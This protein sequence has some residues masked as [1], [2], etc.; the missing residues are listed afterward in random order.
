MEKNVSALD[1]VSRSL[2]FRWAFWFIFANAVALML[3]SLNY[4]KSMQL[5]DT[6]LAQL[7]LSLSYPGHYFSLA[8][9][10]SPFIAAGI[11]AYPR[12][13]FVFGLAI[14]LELTLVLIIILDS[15]VFAQ[16]RFHLNGMVWNLITSGAAGD[17]LPVT[18][19]LWLVL[20]LAIVII[21]FCEWLLAVISWRWVLKERRHYGIGLGALIAFVILVGHGM[22]AWADANHYT[23][24]TNQIRYLPAYK[25]LTMKRLM[26][27]MG[28]STKNEARKLYLNTDN[29]ALRYPLEAVNCINNNKKKNNLLLIVIDS[30]RFDA[31]TPEITPNIWEFSKDSLR[32]DNHFSSGNATRFGI[33]GLFYGLYGTY[34]HALLAEERSPVLMQEMEKQSYRMGVFASAPLVNPEFDRTVFADIRFKI[35]LRQEGE[36]PHQR[37]RT[38]TDKMLNFIATNPAE[39]PFF[40]F[41]F[42]DAPHAA[43][44][45]ADLTPFQPALK[46]VN[47]LALNDSYDPLPFLNKYKNSIHH[48]D[49]MVQEVLAALLNKGLLDNTI[50]VITG[51]HGQEFNDLKMNYWGHTGNFSRFQTQTPLVIHWPGK[52]SQVFTHTTSHL[53]MAPTLM[54]QMLG[55]TNDPKTYS[56]GRYLFD[57]TSRPY[58]LAS[59]WDTFGVIEPDRITVSLNAGELDILDNSYR[60]IM[61]AKVR[62]EITRSAMQG[63]GKFF[64]R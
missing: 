31:L 21:A 10:V 60:P 24:I 27:R 20:F 58:V 56:N 61:G 4:L 26:I 59:S 32:F 62:P 40:G 41:L 1:R 18:G 6:P 43:D 39:T 57:T 19:I 45:P 14:F 36:Q 48:V 50:V 34:W 29:S 55:C 64:G 38:I 16:Y 5:P 44:H 9:Y 42:Y 51:D 22:H 7:F 11:L 63:I 53:D 49:T 15:L 28:L 17:V 30:W 52:A 46:E 2:M 8:M 54:H 13:R 12:R 3:I 33:F 25:P 37:D 47:Y 35:S 23:M